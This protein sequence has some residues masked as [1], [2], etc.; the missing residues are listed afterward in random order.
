MN[1]N[2]ETLQLCGVPLFQ[3]IEASSL[4]RLAFTSERYEYGPGEVICEQGTEGDGAFVLLSGKAEV[5]IRTAPGAEM[6]SVSE[7]GP[8]AI[9]GEM[10]TLTGQLRSATVR[11]L[12]PVEALQI[13]RDALLELL[14]NNPSAMIEVLRVLAQRLAAT[15]DELG[16][17]RTIHGRA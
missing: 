4:R 15:T 16:R 3:R 11:A 2:D 10:A 6:V 1:L 13:P 9:V 17:L 5:L 12:T 7:L 14:N 8:N